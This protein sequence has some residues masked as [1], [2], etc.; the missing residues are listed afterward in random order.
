MTSN[1]N[2]PTISKA[3]NMSGGLKGLIG[4]KMTKTVKFMGEDI[5]ISKLTVAEVLAI[6][7]KAK[8]LEAENSAGLEVLKTVICAAVEDAKELSDSDFEAFP[9]DELSKLSAE[10]VKY[11]G[12][13][14]EQ[15]K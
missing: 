5:K 3:N 6:Q 11:S 8:A 2:I 15:G 1:I 7:E 10:I 9:M 13:G 14:A 12:M 4:R